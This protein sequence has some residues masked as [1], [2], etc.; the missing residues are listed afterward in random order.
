MQ[1]LSIPNHARVT[2]L[3]AIVTVLPVLPDTL[4]LA[5]TRSEEAHGACLPRYTRENH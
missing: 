1:Q 5:K 4:A 3:Q 2:Q